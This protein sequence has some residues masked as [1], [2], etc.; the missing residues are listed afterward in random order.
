METSRR[1]FDPLNVW[2]KGCT[3]KIDKITP[4]KIVVVFLVQEYL[5]VKSEHEN[6]DIYPANYSKRFCMLLLKLIQYPDMSYKDLHDFLSAPD[7]GIE[8]NHLQSFEELMDTISTLGVDVLFDLQI[9]IGKLLTENFH[10]NQ[11]GIV[12]FY[13]RRILLALNKMGFPEIIE[14]YKNINTYYDKGLRAMAFSSTNTNMSAIEPNDTAGG[15]S[16][17]ADMSS[18]L[19]QQSKRHLSL[20]LPPVSTS[21]ERNGHSKWSVKQADLFIAQQ[22]N[23]LENNETLALKPI[24]LQ[25]RLNEII[26]DIPFYTQAHALTYLNSLRVRDF[27]S[28]LD[29]YH[30]AYDQSSSRETASATATTDTN[31]SASTN[32]QTKSSNKGLQY[33]S[34]NL[35]VLHMQFGH[36]NETH[37]NLRECIMLAQE[38]GDKTCLQLAQL[39]LCLLDKKYVMLCESN[40]T[41]QLES[42]TVHS[43]SLGVQFVVNLAATSGKHIKFPYKI[44]EKLIFFCFLFYFSLTEGVVPS[45][46]FELLMKSEVMNFQHSLMG[47]VSISLS[48]KSAVWQLYGKTEL[49]SLCNQLL[50]QVVRSSKESDAIENNESVCL[51]LCCVTLW[52]SLQGDSSLAALVIQHASD[53]F[54]RDPHS[55]HWQM[56]EAYIQ[57]Q[58]AIHQC[59]WTDGLKACGLINVYDPTLSVIQQ[60]TLNIARGN[61]TAAQ[62]QLQQLLSDSQ[63]EPIYRVRAM[64]L[65]SN[66]F[67]RSELISNG[68]KRFSAE[69]MGILNDASVYA[70]EKYLSYEAAIVDLHTTYILLLMGMP[71]QAL[72]LIRNCMETILANGGIYDCAKTQF[73]FVKSLVAAQGNNTVEKIHKLSATLPILEE[74]IQNFM[75]LGAYAK[76]KDVYIYLSMIYDSLDL[77]AER[78]KWA[79]KF[80]NL[81]EQFATPTEYLNV[82][83]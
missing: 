64:I 55:R 19:H 59:R 74:C 24:E 28:S 60:A 18:E 42:S 7:V 37:S 72:K 52:L 69:A 79:Y 26:E 47:L 36:Y 33:S 53:R 3:N 38:A 32:N 73:L 13:I 61:G 30:H 11:F 80:R 5:K 14:L 46:L 9:F 6:H 83:L 70:K 66:T 78:N 56:T 45:K 77:P 68:D 67:F 12:G 76:V 27:F 10:V 54:P 81:E 35:A 4:H 71:Q 75:K 51:S 15:S 82:F 58:Y 31:Q 40:V 39:W 29:S 1:E 2:S 44:P 50:L 17:I 25:Q 63:L 23:L 22:C 57:S 41:S 48:Q 62:R 34:L 16:M 65:I 43:V 20:I 8:M 49:A 21:K